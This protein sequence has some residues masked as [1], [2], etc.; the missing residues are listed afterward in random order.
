MTLAVMLLLALLLVTFT[1]TWTTAKAI[2]QPR[3]MTRGKAFHLLQRASPADLNLKFEPIDF[4]VA[5]TAKSR[6]HLAGWWMPHPAGGSKTVILI[7]GY[8]DAKIGAIAWAPLWQQLGFNVL[9]YDQ[10]AHGESGGRYCTG[11]V[12]EADDLR[13]VIDQLRER[14]P[15]PTQRIVLFGISLGAFPALSVACE[16]GNVEAAVVDCPFASYPKAVEGL[17]RQIR[18][19][20]RSLLP[21]TLRLAEWMSGVRWKGR[22]NPFHLSTCRRPVLA[23]SSSDDP[24]VSVEDAKEIEDSIAALGPPSRFR[25][26]EGAAHLRAMEAD[27]LAYQTA[28]ASF[29]DSIASAD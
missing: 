13:Q 1:A 6:I 21:L 9:A 20:L 3:R 15:L 24:Y 25:L 2:L 7:H 23:I 12:R 5:D 10:R 8:A 4:E 14:L 19:P 28:I 18:T 26:V 16:C 27:P 29:L 17:S 11:G 22:S